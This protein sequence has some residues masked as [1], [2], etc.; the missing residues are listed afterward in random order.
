MI[1]TIAQKLLHQWKDNLFN[2]SDGIIFTMKGNKEKEQE[3]ER[4]GNL[5]KKNLKNSFSFLTIN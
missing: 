5:M 2:L 3:Q 1:F 4:R